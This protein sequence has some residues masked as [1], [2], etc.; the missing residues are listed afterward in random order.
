M[1]LI[2]LQCPHNHI[3]V[4]QATPYPASTDANGPMI[5]RIR[6]LI[7]SSL[8]R[9]VLS[10]SGGT[11]GGQLILFAVSPI[12][13]RV[14]V[15]ESFGIYGVFISTIGVIGSFACL[16]FELAI[17]VPTSRRTAKYLLS[18]A[19]LSAVVF[20]LITGMS[21][22]LIESVLK[23]PITGETEVPHLA[24]VLP[25]GVFSMGLY[26]SLSKWAVRSQAYKKLGSA[27][28]L[29]AVY[30]A[31]GQLLAGLIGVQRLGLIIGHIIGQ[32]GAAIKLFAGAKQALLRKVERFNTVRLA[33]TIRRY[34]DFPLI[35]GPS[36]L[37][38]SSGLELPIILIGS[39]IGSNVVGWLVM[40][41]RVLSAPVQVV[42][43]SLA[44]VHLGHGSEMARRNPKRLRRI[45]REWVLKAGGVSIVAG[46]AVAGFLPAA[47][48][49]VFGPDWREAG[50][51]ATLLL[52]MIVG[53]VIAH[54]F[55]YT[56]AMTERQR[57]GLAWSIGRLVMTVGTVGIAIYTDVD[58]RGVVMA[59]SIGMA[60]AYICLYLLADM[61]VGEAI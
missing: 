41:Q 52:P 45:M 31:V 33:A 54:P 59:Y 29:K 55:T 35:T 17:P 20:A 61:V 10:L 38:N 28:L 12:L 60:T 18:A 9:E 47:F 23:R 5:A 22:F 27:K 48:A 49:V 42:T 25:A 58:G 39:F 14:F 57:I 16:R 34:S 7:K 11:A 21:V 26:R 50:V 37:A 46:F 2:L 1:A 24:V 32:A 13:S 19:L 53:Q 44:E 43:I 6:R 30:T 36:A 4:L 3:V 40:A 8:G 15:P 56:F 51:Y